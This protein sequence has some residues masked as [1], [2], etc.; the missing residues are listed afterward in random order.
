MVT[1]CPATAS[2]WRSTTVDPPTAHLP[3]SPTAQYL[4]PPH[5]FT[6]GN[7]ADCPTTVSADCS[8]ANDSSN[9]F[10]NT[11]TDCSTAEF[12][13]AV[14]SPRSDCCSADDV[15][16]SDLARCVLGGAVPRRGPREPDASPDD[17]KSRPGVVLLKELRGESL[18]RFP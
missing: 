14:S 4:P 11:S 10:T 9:S 13:T 17:S 3:S 6:A 15:L 5:C 16:A 18:T 2:T 12:S 1:D 7:T 8:T